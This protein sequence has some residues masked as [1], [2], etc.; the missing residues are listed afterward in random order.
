MNLILEEHTNFEAS[1]NIF[2]SKSWPSLFLFNS[3]VVFMLLTSPW[4]LIC[5]W[6]FLNHPEHFGQGYSAAVSFGPEK[7]SMNLPSNALD[8]MTNKMSNYKFQYGIIV[9][10]HFKNLP[11]DN[12]IAVLDTS[13]TK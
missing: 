2:S 13:G 3:S 11:S 8:V 12:S 4:L 9:T 6:T 5:C 10:T 1:A 7:L